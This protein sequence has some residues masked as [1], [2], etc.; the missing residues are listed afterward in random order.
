MAQLVDELNA[1]THIGG[2]SLLLQEDH[3]GTL[4][5]RGDR[6]WEKENCFGWYGFWHF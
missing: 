6:P 4:A 1:I 3:S 2:V 5:L